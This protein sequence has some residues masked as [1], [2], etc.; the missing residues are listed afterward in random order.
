[1]AML[2]S[3]VA[4]LRVNA[5]AVPALL[6]LLDN[7]REWTL[8]GLAER[9]GVTSSAMGLTVGRLERDLLVTRAPSQFDQRFKAIVPTDHARSLRTRLLA[10]QERCE[11][12]ALAGFN[13][14]ERDALHGLISRLSVQLI[15]A[16]GGFDE[17]LEADEVLRPSQGRGC[18]ADQAEAPT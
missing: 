11:A 14:N 10:A 18:Y 15:D 6:A 13:P 9:L 1:M 16:Q 2:R 3:E 7:T 5:G 12:A 8:A 17:T 4:N